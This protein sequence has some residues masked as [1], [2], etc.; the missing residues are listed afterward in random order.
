ME[1]DAIGEHTVRYREERDRTEPDIGTS[2]I[3]LKT[4]E[5]NIMSEESS[6]VHVCVH[7]HILVRVHALVR[8]NVCACIHVHLHFHV[9]AT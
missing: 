2:D 8:V 4:A 3:G 6:N 7:V 5:S 9:H 1:L